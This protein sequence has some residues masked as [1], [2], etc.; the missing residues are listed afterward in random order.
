MAHKYKAGREWTAKDEERAHEQ[1]EEL[2]S[3]DRQIW[4]REQRE[5]LQRLAKITFA[6]FEGALQQAI[7]KLEVVA[8]ITGD[9][10]I[11]NDLPRLATMQAIGEL[12]HRDQP[13]N[14]YKYLLG[15]DPRIVDYIQELQISPQELLA[16]LQ[17][18]QKAI[19]EDEVKKTHLSKT[20]PLS[21]RHA[22]VEAPSMAYACWNVLKDLK[23]GTDW[24]HLTKE[25]RTAC[26]QYASRA[27]I[28]AEELKPF[29]PPGSVIDIYAAK[30][31]KK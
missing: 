26:E 29:L 30:K 9:Q 27:P 8:H 2:T 10:R 28:F 1:V 4:E 14:I 31:V 15:L 11:A 13:E 23:E 25:E 18:L 17:S 22:S 5:I 3:E 12:V 24:K 19:R 6:E 16:Y 7:Q 20:R 21:K